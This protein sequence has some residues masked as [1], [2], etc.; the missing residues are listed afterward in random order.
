MLLKEM[1]WKLYKTHRNLVC[2]DVITCNYS[3]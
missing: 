3:Y 1:F 2:P